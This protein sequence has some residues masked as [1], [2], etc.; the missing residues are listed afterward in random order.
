[1]MRPTRSLLLLA[2]LVG[3]DDDPARQRVDDPAD[4]GDATAPDTGPALDAAPL[5]LGPDDAAPVDADVPPADALLPDAAPPVPEI[6]NGQDEDADGLIDEGVA[7]VCGG[8]GGCP[9]RAARP[10]ASTSS[11]GSTA[12]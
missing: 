6:C 8:C 3:C 12:G 7:N 5:D 4:A 9:P 2:L 11:R 1:M 10:G